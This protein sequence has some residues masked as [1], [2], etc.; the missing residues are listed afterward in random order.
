MSVDT[1]VQMQ[2]DTSLAS[3][4][5]EPEQAADELQDTLADPLESEGDSVQ[6]AVGG[7]RG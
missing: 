1:D 4:V 7:R 2:Q 3:T 5:Q 6:M